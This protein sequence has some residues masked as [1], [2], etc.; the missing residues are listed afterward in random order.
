MELFIEK[1]PLLGWPTG[2]AIFLINDCCEKVQATV[3]DAATGQGVLGF[4]V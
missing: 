3:G 4:I 2:G 1:M